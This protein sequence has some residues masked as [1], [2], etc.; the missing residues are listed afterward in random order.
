[1]PAHTP[2]YE[3]Q[4][5]LAREG[6]ELPELRGLERIGSS[7]EFG[8]L[9]L[10]LVE[11]DGWTVMRRPRVGGGE[12]I[13]CARGDQRVCRDADMLADVAVDVFREAMRLGGR[14][15]EAA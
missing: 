6:A 7:L 12:I 3:N 10:R 1:M 8:S 2:V 11:L 9:L 5:A 4:L 13:E 14:L 15:L